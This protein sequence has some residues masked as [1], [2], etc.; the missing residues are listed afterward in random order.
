MLTRSAADAEVGKRDAAAFVRGAL[1][2]AL[3]LVPAAR[4]F[5]QQLLDTC[6]VRFSDLVDSI[7]IR[8]ATA[9]PAMGWR[10]SGPGVWTHPRLALPDVLERDKPCIAFRVEDLEHLLNMLGLETPVEGQAFGPF[11]R[12]RVFAAS[13]V[14]FDAVERNGS[15]THEALYLPERRIRRALIHQQLFRT[16]RRE[17]R[18]AEKGMAET[19]RLVSAA[20]ADLGPNWACDLFLRAEREHWM[21]WCTAGLIQFRRQKRAGIGWSNIDHYTY[22]ASREQAH[23]AMQMLLELGFQLDTTLNV[24]GWASQVVRQPVLGAVVTIDLDLGANEEFPAQSLP[25][26]LWHGCAG[27]WVSLHGEGLLEG[28]LH[29]VACLLDRSAFPRLAKGDGVSFIP[30]VSDRHEFFQQMTLADQRAIG[31]RRIDRLEQHELITGRQ[32]EHFRLHGGLAAH[33]ECVERNDGFSGF[34][35]PATAP[36]SLS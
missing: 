4:N 29:H 6:A 23:E 18:S 15:N 32:A 10:R 26:L 20:V 17:F 19:R 11:R 35:T 24:D 8:D 31:P 2:Q 30:P 21:R 5:Q 7:G 16:R 36:V 13:D 33:L 27:L 34:D 25:P 9:L 3:E 28:G 14:S 12:A 22:L 1:Q